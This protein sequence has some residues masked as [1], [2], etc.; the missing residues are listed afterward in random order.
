[1]KK[2]D[3]YIEASINKEASEFNI[4]RVLLALSGGPDS[5][6]T[7]FA[8]KK[9]GLEIMALHCN[10]HLR[11]NESNRDMDFVSHFCEL[12][13]IPLEI[14]NFDVPKYLET[15]KKESIEMA[16][17][18]LRYD[19]FNEKLLSSGF[20]RLTTG[21]NADDNIETFFLN[22]LRGSGTRGLKG[23]KKD[24]G[25]IWRPLLNFSRDEILIYLLRNKISYVTD[26][27]NLQSDFRR[28]YI[29]NCVIPLLKNEWKGFNH[30]MQRTI[31]NL[32]EE[33]N[34]VEHYIRETLG[35]SGILRTDTVKQFPSPLLLVK[36][37]ID[38]LGPFTT[39]PSEVLAAIKA[40]KPH[41]RKWQLRNGTLI[42]RNGQLTVE[43]SHGISRSR[44]T[45]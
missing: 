28:N 19:W 38:P 6:A 42:L 40:N 36:R 3:F 32:S 45:K 26:S 7:A 33:N 27:T 15:H 16:C 2:K 13:K 35:D 25:K 37:F 44:E 14:A 8:L 5:I 9:S 17:R 43:M 41:I 30:V 29:R 24:T 12:N 20:D 34:I 11:G 1:M 22:M 10:F 31:S 4:K 39:T 18:N 23:M 21:H